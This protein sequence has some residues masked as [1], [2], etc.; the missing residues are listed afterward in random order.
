MAKSSIVV[1]GPEP[2]KTLTIEDYQR[3]AKSTAIYPGEMAF[4]G[5]LYCILGLAG[6]AGEV[7]NTTKKI[8]RDDGGR[9]TEDRRQKLKGELGDVAWY[10]AQ[11]CTELGLSLED[12]MRQNL[13]K[14][15]KR[16]LDNKLKGEG[17][18]R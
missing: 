10:L 11:A 7:S 2:Q 6:E 13:V 18:E 16:Q 14:L 9:L 12:V 3:G 5:I 4:A 1:D 17:S 15:H 8:L